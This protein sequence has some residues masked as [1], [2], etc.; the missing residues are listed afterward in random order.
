MPLSHDRMFASVDR[1]MGKCWVL[2]LNARFIYVKNT[3]RYFVLRIKNVQFA[4]ETVWIRL[5]WD[6]AKSSSYTSKSA[7]G[8]LRHNRWQYVKFVCLGLTSLLNSHIATVPVC[9]SGT[10]TNV[11]P[12]RDAMPQTQ[13]MTPPRHSIQTQ[14]RPVAVLS[15][16][17]ERHTE[18]HSFPF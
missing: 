7:L 13:D 8:W 14:G 12:H 11:L 5:C 6:T 18:I 17:V 3:L 2:K 16:D 10:L 9:S 15:I 4:K 1:R